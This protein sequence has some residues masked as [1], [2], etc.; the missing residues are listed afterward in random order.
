MNQF[1]TGFSPTLLDIDNKIINQITTSTHL[2]EI[3]LPA[4]S[5]ENIE[6]E[7]YAVNI[8]APEFK[9]V[10]G[11]GDEVPYTKGL[12]FHGRIK[13]NTN[14]I[15]AI[16]ITN[17]E[18]S[19]LISDK[20]G[21]RMLKKHSNNIYSLYYEQGLVNQLPFKCEIVGETIPAR[22]SNSSTRINGVVSCKVVNIYIEADHKLYNDNGESISATTNLVTQLFNQVAVL[23]KNENL[24]INLS[25][26]KVWST[27]DPYIDKTGSD[28]LDMMKYNLGT[29]FNGN[30]AHLLSGRNLKGGLAGV[31][32]L[33]DK[34]EAVGYSTIPFGGYYNGEYTDSPIG[35]IA[36]ELGHS[37][38][39]R[40]TQWCGW[41]GGPIDN[42]SQTENDDGYCGPNFE[43]RVD[44][45]ECSRGPQPPVGGGTIMSYCHQKSNVGI[46]LANGF[47]PQP[48]NKIRENVA[49]CG[50]IIA[51]HADPTNPVTTNISATAATVSWAMPIS[52]T[53]FTVRYRKVGTDTWITK[54]GTGSSTNLTGL[55]SGVQYQWQ[56]TGDCSNEGYTG[57]LN[58]STIIDATISVAIAISVCQGGAEN[59]TLYYTKSGTIN[60]GNIFTA[61]LSDASGNFNSPLNLGTVTSTTSGTIP[62]NIPSNISGNG[63]K[64]R[65]ISSFPYVNGYPREITIS[66]LPSVPAINYS[67]TNSICV[68]Q[69]TTLSVNNCNGTVLWQ[70]NASGNYE[71]IGSGTSIQVSPIRNTLYH[72]TCTASNGCTNAKASTLTVVQTPTAPSANILACATSPTT[73]WAKKFGGSNYE[74]LHKVLE[75]TDGNLLWIGISSSQTSGDKSINN[76]GS[77]D[78]WVI[79]TDATGTTILWQK[80]YGGSAQESSTV[81]IATIDS[82][83]I[84]GMSSRSGANGNKS[85]ANFGDSD[86]WLIKIDANGNITRQWTFGGNSGDTPQSLIA[87]S[88]GN[89]L[90]AASSYSVEGTG[91]R[92]LTAP[93]RGAGNGDIWLIKFD[94]NSPNPNPLAATIW[95]S[96]YGGDGNDIPIDAIETP[97]GDFIIG[98]WSRSNGGTGNK[99][100]VNFDG[101][102]GLSDYWVL[103]IK[104]DG[105]QILWQRSYGGAK[106][107]NNPA[108]QSY[109]DDYL[110]S[111][112]KSNTNGKYV[113]GGQ[114]KSESNTGN[115]LT[116]LRGNFDGWI[117]EINDSDGAK[118]GERTIGGAN[119]D[120]FSKIVRMPNGNGYWTTM[121]VTNSNSIDITAPPLGM[122]DF[123]V[124]EIDNNLASISPTSPRWDRRLGG[125]LGAFD[126]IPSNLT[127]T[128]AGDLIVSGVRASEVSNTDGIAQDYFA[129]KISECSLS[130]STTA[131]SGSG[132]SL[133]ASGCLG[134][135]N[136]SNGMSGST[137]SVNTAGTYTATCIANAANCPS[138]TSNSIVISSIAGNLTLSSTA[139]SGVQKAGLTISSTQIIPSGANVTYQAGNSVNLQGTFTAR[140]GSVFKAEIKGCN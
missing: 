43:N 78:A 10:N 71:Q 13:G 89:Y 45:P 9:V 115:K 63:Y 54:S 14:S 128:K 126:D 58:F 28:I 16:S 20:T 47:G 83:A 140:S 22:N 60:E 62:I 139:T 118:V 21:D 12:H 111:L 49:N 81:S 15:A 107:A 4:N 91:N 103:K 29:I 113:L 19:G 32:K 31:D 34:S 117:I 18:V 100:A 35:E 108:G 48:G 109:G 51:N 99:T 101:N 75:L 41:N 96:S 138:S 69:S 124:A 105:T 42:C 26:V 46:N 11:K 127:L 53:N 73:Q 87:T 116:P 61:Q 24:G 129:V 82:G 3:S 38:G 39:S 97:T 112:T 84:I 27:T 33:C 85:T 79:K 36:H 137:I 17:G 130:S 125:S 56:V 70:T 114:S 30:V 1:K 77:D 131:C 74:N 133:Y 37:F 94:P 135:V 67:P 7:L 98:A 23:Y 59:G 72:A 110:T 64:V 86:I 57:T 2:L 5:K 121:K 134:T 40:H 76:F 25:H 92:E 55:L 90:V 104:G 123:W 52:S 136:W 88:D 132:V 122:A 50:H 120:L 6:L 95:Q 119:Q 66:P 80:V 93:R 68:G 106:T 102:A 8:F 65:V 44:C